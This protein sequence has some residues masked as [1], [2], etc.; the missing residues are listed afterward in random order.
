MKKATAVARNQAIVGNCATSGKKRNPQSVRENGTA[1]TPQTH[2]SPWWRPVKVQHHVKEINTSLVVG[3]ET[4][5]VSGKFGKCYLPY[6]RDVV[7]VKE[8]TPVKLWT[9]NDLR[10]EVRHEAKMINHLGDHCSVPLLF[11]VVTNSEPLRLIT[12]VSWPK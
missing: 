12:K 8:Y 6:Y 10:K 5:L 7:V 9:T 4:F 11:G 3:K 2:L 1:E